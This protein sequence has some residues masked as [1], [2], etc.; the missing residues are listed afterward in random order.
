MWRTMLR[1]L[2]AH[3]GR[4]AM[5]LVA[6]TLGVTAVVGAWVVSDSIATTISGQGGRTGVGLSVRAD[7]PDTR[8]PEAEL[9]RLAALPGATATGVRTGH[10]GL[11][12]P[13]GKLVRTRTPLGH[14]GTGWDDTGR[15]TLLSGRPPAAAGEIAVNRVEAAL[16]GL[17]VGARTRVL[18]DGGR[19]EPVTVVGRYDYR[20]LG[21]D[22]QPAVALAPAE[23]ERLLGKG[24]RRIELTGVT[25]AAAAGPG[26][27]VQTGAELAEVVDADRAEGLMDLRIT[28]L[29]FAF[30]AL[31]VGMFV[32]ANTFGMLLIQRTRQL[33]LL[34]AVGA[35]QS[36]VR[37]TVVLEATLLGLA[38]GTLGAGTG[39][40]VGPLII[41]VLRPGEHIEFTV[42]PLAILL[43]YAVAVGTTVLAAYGPARR[44][45]KVSPMAAL[46]T[47]P[48]PPR[49][50]RRART[51]AGLAVLATALVAVLA[52][53]DPSADTLPR[54]IGLS[55]TVVA[56][57]GVLLL[58]PA[59]AALVLRPLSRFG[60]PALRLA[61]RNAA[62]DPRR[63]SATA[64]AITIGVALVCA[65]ATLSATFGDLIASTTRATVPTSTT[66]I[67]PALKGQSHLTRN[68][69]STVDKV[70]SAAT[71]VAAREALAELAYEGGGTRRVVSAIDPAAFGTV[72]T[73]TVTDGVA[74]LRRGALISRNQA[75]MLGLRLGERFTMTFDGVTVASTVAGVYEAT[76]LQAS[77]YFDQAQVP[78]AL[79]DKITTIYATGPDPAA[80]RAAVLAE[81]ADRPDVT[82][83]DQAGL[84]AEGQETQ[85][86][87]FVIMYAMFALAVLISL[88]GV[89]NTLAL[90]VMARVRE[91]GVLRAVGA[92]QSLLRAAIRWESVVI[93]LFGAILGV[94]LGVGSGAVMQHAML[95]QSLLD[96]TVPL[97]VVALTLAGLVTA[98]VL[99]AIW[100]ARRAARIDLLTAVAS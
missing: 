22:D 27:V 76:E 36:Q 39:V 86:L 23:A 68:D 20:T 54:I 59:L 69:L 52:T 83:T 80:T 9:A 8:L 77:I 47:D 92:T 55:A 82:V 24:F 84:V 70:P 4:V 58:A 67:R 35:R 51:L 38:G 62:G 89:V 72:L 13:D 73:P 48:T 100:P 17:D 28:L 15:F 64:T 53:A 95:G 33:A 65:F 1:D 18:L 96:A 56:A 41:G 97:P 46:R 93:C 14:T 78:P 98:G 25:P 87:A 90:A 75:D 3:K 37:R 30:V 81:F 29:P 63:T 61:I 99:A 91:L 49:A 85:R 66:V 12:G 2:L 71:V 34:R 21:E 32:I 57:L 44:A 11:P 50:T 19:W 5:T 60:S 16:A 79:Q 7:R 94:L 45:A 40:A 26:R 74:D 31:M 10:A 88:F 42:S 43:G 6:I